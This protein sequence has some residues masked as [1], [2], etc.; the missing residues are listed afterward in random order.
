MA[1]TIQQRKD[2]RL[3][4]GGSDIAAIVGINKWLTP[5]DVYLEK[6]S[7]EEPYE[8]ERSL[9]GP[10]PTEWGNIMEPVIIKHFERA[11]GL[12]CITELETFVHP[13]YPYMRA[14]VDAKVL[15]EDALL[16]CKTAGQFM[17]KEWSSLGGDNIPEPYLLQCAY[18]A[19]VANVSKVYIAVLIGGNDFR[20]YNYDRNAALGKLILSKVTNFWENHVLKEIPPEPI[21]LEDS[22]KLWKHTTGEDAK[23]ATPDIEFIIKDLRALKAQEKA[24]KTLYAE[25]QLQVCNFLE[26]DIAIN[27]E[28]GQTLLTWKPQV[29]NRFD[30]A[31]FKA[32]HPEMYN[33]YIKTT[34][35][36]VF[37]LKGEIE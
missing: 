30:G 25:K 9:I 36:R 21:N 23:A 32:E 28:N 18:Y 10:N 27:D 31:A 29:I 16:E 37:K 14:N 3:G 4:I 1:L 8:E 6:I 12:N 15:G 13:E 7:T 33:N 5:L 11:V 24:I 17:A 22:V 26:A 2:R 19:E 35:S 34:Q 20:I